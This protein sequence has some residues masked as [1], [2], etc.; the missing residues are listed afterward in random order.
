MSAGGARWRA[1]KLLVER[2]HFPSRARA[3]AEIRAGTVSADGARIR[4]PSQMLPGNA[5]IALAEPAQPYASRAGLK[6][7]H[8]LDRFGLEPGGGVA[9]DLGASTG[10][11]TDVLLRRGARK[12]YAIDV[13]HGQM[14]PPLRAD[15][16]VCVTEGLNARDLTRTHVPEP[17]D[18]F[19]A[20]VSFISL[21]LVLPAALALGCPGAWAVVLVKPQFEVGRASIGKGGVVRDP[22]AHAEAAERIESVFAAAG[23]ETAGREPS[24]ITGS[25]GNVEILLAARNRGQGGA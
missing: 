20:D 6:L 12:V 8:A 4:A 7:A 19:V 21:A 25:D 11:F 1:D 10:G 13:G 9:L 16:R 22:A 15:S 5:A 3:A 24:P 17:V 14:A 2:G 18:C 23:W